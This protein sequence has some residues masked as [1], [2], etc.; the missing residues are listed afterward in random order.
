MLNLDQQNV[1]LK[2][3]INIQK[4]HSFTE[5]DH[6]AVYCLQLYGIYKRLNFLLHWL[7]YCT[8]SISSQL[9]SQKIEKRKQIKNEDAPAEIIVAQ[10]T[11][12]ESSTLNA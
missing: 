2:R 12:C 10:C 7:D 9:K 1:N 11:L 8:K 5:L 6:C 4:C 3:F